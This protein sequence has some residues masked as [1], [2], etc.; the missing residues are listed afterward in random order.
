MRD[1]LALLL[2]FV[3]LLPLPLLRAVAARPQVHL[4]NRIPLADRP[5][6]LFD[7]GV[8]DEDHCNLKLTHLLGEPTVWAQLK[9]LDINM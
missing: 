6:A 8:V 1:V 7:I 4:F 5:K 2:M 9:G 3:L